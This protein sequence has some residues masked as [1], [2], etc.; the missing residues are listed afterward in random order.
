MFNKWIH[1]EKI[2]SIETIMDM[3]ELIT[4][5]IKTKEVR[6]INLVILYKIEDKKGRTDLNDEWIIDW[7]II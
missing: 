6:V 5:Q 4:F 3:K 7:L 1:Q 2:K